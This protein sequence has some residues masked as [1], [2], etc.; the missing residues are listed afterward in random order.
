MSCHS[1][2]KKR[3]TRVGSLLL[4]SV[5]WNRI[6]DV[7]VLLGRVTLIK[8][9]VGGYSELETKQRSIAKG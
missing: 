3:L 7:Q 2:V 8:C 9:L 6:R 1:H 5:G 4:T